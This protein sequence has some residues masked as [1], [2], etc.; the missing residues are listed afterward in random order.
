MPGNWAIR[1]ARGGDCNLPVWG[2][3]SLQWGS[4]L[5]EMSL[6]GVVL[7]YREERGGGGGILRHLVLRGKLGAVAQGDLLEGGV[8][9]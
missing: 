3:A 1:V 5:V 8:G 6:V 4:C 7:K 9:W 2:S